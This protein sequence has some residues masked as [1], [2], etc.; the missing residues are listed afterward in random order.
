[1]LEFMIAM[2]VIAGLG[3]W[4]LARSWREYHSSQQT[5]S[6]PSAV[7]VWAVYL[8]HL[9]MTIAASFQGTW[10]LGLPQ[11]VGWLGLLLMVLGALMFVLGIWSFHSFQRVSGLEADALVTGGIYR[12]SRNPQNVGWGFFLAGMAVLGQSALAL[13]LAALFWAVF[14]AYVPMEERYLQEVFGEEYRRY[15]RWS[16]RFLGPPRNN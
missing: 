12:W 13:L 15:M 6:L 4:S 16:H 8:S 9:A 1:M 3:L 7:G 5:R 14:I 10:P 11:V 2:A